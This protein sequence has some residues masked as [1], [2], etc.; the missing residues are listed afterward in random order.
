VQKGLREPAARQRLESAGFEVMATSPAEATA[1]L[2]QET[3]RWGG[4]IR[5]LNIRLDG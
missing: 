2:A 3:A 1:F 4:M 5:R